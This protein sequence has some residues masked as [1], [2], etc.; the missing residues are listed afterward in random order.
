[1]YGTTPELA[2]AENT[3]RRN[4]ASAQLHRANRARRW[5]VGRVP[6]PLTD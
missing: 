4:R 6:R 2:K 1:M 3:Y 5:H